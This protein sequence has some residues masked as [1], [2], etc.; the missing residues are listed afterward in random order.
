MDRGGFLQAGRTVTLCLVRDISASGARLSVDHPA[1]LPEEITIRVSGPDSVR[2]NAR[3][4]WRA[5]S[6]VGIEFVPAEIHDAPPL[7][8]EAPRRARAEFELEPA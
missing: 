2:R 4:V 5:G 8:P 6:E 7:V 3:I 1:A